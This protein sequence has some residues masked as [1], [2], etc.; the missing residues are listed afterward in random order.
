MKKCYQF[1]TMNM[2]DHGYS[3]LAYY[4]DLMWPIIVGREPKKEWRLPDWLDK[5]GPEDLLDYETVRQYLIY[6][7]CGKPFC[8]VVDQD[9]RQH[10]PGHAEIS[11]RRW[12]Q[13]SDDKTIANLIRSD[14]DIHLLKA[15]G[16]EEF[17][18][19]PEAITLLIA[20]LCE[21]HSNAQMFGGIESTSFKIKWK[22]LNKIG[23]R[24]TEKMS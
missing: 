8:R 2:L 9:G 19:R 11:Y 10:F 7:D 3:V 14:M 12:L 1:E 15:D 6:H 20:A 4:D 21:I 18:K 17:L 13:Y 22:H 16:I 5:I 24:L 23:R